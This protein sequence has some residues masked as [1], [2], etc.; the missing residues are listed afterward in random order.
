MFS[1]E[2]LNRSL[3]F[4]WDSPKDK[5]GEKTTMLSKRLRNS[6]NL[7]NATVRNQVTEISR[8]ETTANTVHR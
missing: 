2:V 5:F 4:S 8:I 3:V 7:R 6:M 1:R